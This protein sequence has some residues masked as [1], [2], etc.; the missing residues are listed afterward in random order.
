MQKLVI[1]LFCAILALILVKA[2]RDD[3]SGKFAIKFMTLDINLPFGYIAQWALIYGVLYFTVA[4]HS[5][6]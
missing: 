5:L 1:P 6:F 2:L 3:E 4:D